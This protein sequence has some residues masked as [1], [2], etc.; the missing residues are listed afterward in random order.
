MKILY[1]EGAGCEG[2]QTGEISN[3]R[4]RTAFTNNEGNKVYLEI[5]GNV[6]TLK[7]AKEYNRYKNYVVGEAIGFIDFC[8]YIT[9]DAKIDDCNNS[10]LPCERKNN[11]SY[12]YKGILDFVNK[13][14]N[15]SF[16]SIEVL[17][18]MSGYRVHG[19]GKHNTFAAYNYGDEY[20]YNK[21]LETKREN[22]RTELENHFC[23]VFNQKY[24]NT[25][26]WCI[27]NEDILHVQINVSDQ[28]RKAAGYNERCFNVQL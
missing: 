27:D 2:T 18:R 8:F 10:R 13:Q 14:C 7:D 11:I 6:K 23:K 1:F 12:S 16:D 17:G 21:E 24:D 26:I 3:C 22:K 20:Q 19:D 15:C 28:V 4:I 5:L 25:S 9:D